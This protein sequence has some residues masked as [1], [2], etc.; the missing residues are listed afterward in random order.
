MLPKPTPSIYIHIYIYICIY[1]CICI[2]IYICI[3]RQSLHLWVS[4]DA[5]RLCGKLKPDEYMKGVVFFYADLLSIFAVCLVC[6]WCAVACSGGD[7]S[8]GASGADFAYGG[9]VVCCLDGNGGAGEADGGSSAQAEQR[10]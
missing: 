2:Y 4:F 7:A 5:A 1:I 10:V 3:P 8:A 6:A 9:T